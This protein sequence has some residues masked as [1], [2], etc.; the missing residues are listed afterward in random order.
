MFI[1]EGGEYWW[2]MKINFVGKLG[3]EMAADFRVGA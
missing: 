3:L 1:G 2:V